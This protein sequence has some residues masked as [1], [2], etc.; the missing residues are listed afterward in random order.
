MAK[1]TPKGIIWLA[2]YPKSGNTWTRNF[3]HNL[4]NVM[5][6]DASGSQDINR[7]NSMSTWEIAAAPYEK[8]LGKSVDQCSREEI[9]SVRH[10][11]Q[12]QIADNADGLAFV[13]THHALVMDRELPTI[14][15]DVT[16]GAIYIVRNPLDV[17]ISFSHHM[18]TSIDAAIDQMAVDGLETPIGEK[19]VYEVYS[20]WSQH[21]ES[22]TRKPHRTIYVMRYEDMLDDPET[23][24]GA[25]AEHLLL[26]P[27][28]SELQRAIALSSFASL[29]KQESEKG[30]REKPKAAQKF[31]RSGKADQWR[32]DL[33][34][35][36]VNRIVTAHGT[37]M[38]RFNYLP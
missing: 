38:Q 1:D 7:M 33:T 25:L 29:Q 12:K 8:L 3:L 10:I 17:A 11:V 15:F 23:T 36:Q 37:Q 30:F 32:H 16:S 27:D 6:G 28:A 34:P 19:S 21:V 14:N 2:S 35:G 24:F 26:K 13:K 5:S 20:S 22:W 4:I 31:F 9:A 18:G